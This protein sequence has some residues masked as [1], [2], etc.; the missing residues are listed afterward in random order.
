MKNVSMILKFRIKRG[1]RSGTSETTSEHR[2]YAP[3]DTLDIP[4][5]GSLAFWIP[6]RR[7]PI[8]DVSALPF[9]QHT[10]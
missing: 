5:L 3:K 2:I 1:E 7:H 10:G 4:L 6:K 9:C 8:N